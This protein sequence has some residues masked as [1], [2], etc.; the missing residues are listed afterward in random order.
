MENCQ[1]CGALLD[2]YS[3]TCKF[4]GNVIFDRIK[5][6]PETESSLTFEE[7]MNIIEEN[8]NTLHELPLPSFQEAFLQVIRV[9]LIIMTFGIAAAF[10]KKEKIRFNKGNYEKLKQ[11]IQ[12]N[13]QY[14]NKSSIGAN[15]LKNKIQVAESEFR[16]IDTKIKNGIMISTATF[17][18]VPILIFTFFRLNPKDKYVEKENFKER[19]STE[20]TLLFPTIQNEAD[21]IS[22]FI[23]IKN[24]TFYIQK[25]ADKY[26]VR[27]LLQIP[28]EKFKTFNLKQFSGYELQVWFVEK[29]NDNQWNSY[30]LKCEPGNDENAKFFNFLMSGNIMSEEISFYLKELEMQKLAKWN[31]EK[32]SGNFIIRGKLM[33]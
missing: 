22:K 3:F 14:L 24:R 30:C 20:V 27:Y 32:C 33:K 26:G 6:T 21:S 8:I 9:Y 29:Q 18:I 1:N 28:F 7:G 2:S 4:C 19:N 31:K 11:I 5:R 17:I 12:R 15:D 16:Q 13:I 23:S 10:W 25:K